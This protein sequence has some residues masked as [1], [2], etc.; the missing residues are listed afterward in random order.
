[1]VSNKRNIYTGRKKWEKKSDRWNLSNVKENLMIVSEK[2]KEVPILSILMASKAP[3]MSKEETNNYIIEGLV[4][5]S[6]KASKTIGNALTFS[7]GVKILGSVRL[8]C[9]NQSSIF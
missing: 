3:W 6:N 2:T 8:N 7:K 5:L 1:M 4:K 9:N